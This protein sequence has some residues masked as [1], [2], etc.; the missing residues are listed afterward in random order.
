M[1]KRFGKVAVLMGGPSAERS[2]SLNSGQAVL[3]A[4][5]RQEID[6]V[7]ID[8]DLN[9]LN[10]L[11]QENFDRVFIALHGRW[12]EDGVIQGGLE[13]IGMPYTGAGVMACAIAMD[14]GITKH[15]WR[16]NNLPTS[17]FRVAC[18]ESDLKGVVD[19]LGLPLYVKA[20]CKGSSV[21]VIKVSKEEEL[22]SAW[23]AA[24]EYDSSVLVEE[25]NSGDELTVAILAG[26]ALPVIRIKVSNEFYD[27]QAKYESDQT[28]YLCPAGLNDELEYQVKSL[29]EKSFSVLGGR[30]WGRVDIM[31]DSQ[32]KPQLLEVNMVPGMTSHSLVPMAA[33]A[34]GLSFDDLVIKILEE[35]L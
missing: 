23:K 22:L 10:R 28:E 6:A 21:G 19:E 31:L 25:F 29:A 26:K 7:G 1:R 2:V 18:Q 13:S 15:I 34:I 12:G 20:I 32:N 27:F 14:K 9:T 30:G 4:M 35:T 33:K 3:D 16:S 11:Q 5:L 17:K 8:A 24:R